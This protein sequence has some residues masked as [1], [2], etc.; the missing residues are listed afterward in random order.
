[1]TRISTHVLDA[2]RGCPGAGITVRL[3]RVGDP[4]VSPATAITDDDGRVADFG[5]D[6]RPAGT[7]R[8]VFETAPYFEAWEQP[9]FFPAVEIMFVV[10]DAR[11]HYHV[12]VLLSPFAYSTYRG[13]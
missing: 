4:D 7:Y 5:S 9:V 11:D 13:S 12:P 10:E 3:H 8:L 1:M 2:S 6:S